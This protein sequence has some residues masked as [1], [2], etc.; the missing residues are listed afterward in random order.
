MKRIEN[1]KA[2]LKD[3]KSKI[4]KV[5]FSILLI[6]LVIVP[7]VPMLLGLK[8]RPTLLDGATVLVCFFAILSLIIR[9][10]KKYIIP[11]IL[12]ESDQGKIYSMVILV[13]IKI[14]YGRFFFLGF[15]CTC[16]G[17]IS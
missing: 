10:S 2:W 7:I 11:E 8:K 16:W 3:N 5:I 12:K 13:I 1:L 14:T 9:I 17:Y 6:K 15:I 4:T